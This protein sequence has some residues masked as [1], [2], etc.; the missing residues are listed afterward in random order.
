MRASFPYG[1]LQSSRL[2]KLDRLRLNKPVVSNPKLEQQFIK[3]Q[4]IEA[5]ESCTFAIEAKGIS[6]SFGGRR[7]RFS[8]LLTIVSLRMQKHGASYRPVDA[9]A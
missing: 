8:V 7:V 5:C 1:T 6:K 4:A 3:C 2:A 9:G